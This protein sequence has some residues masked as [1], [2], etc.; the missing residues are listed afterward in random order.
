MWEYLLLP[1]AVIL[2]L[3]MMIRPEWF[4]KAEHFLDVVDGKPTEWYLAKMRLI[5][6]GLFLIGAVTGIALLIL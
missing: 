6:A 2:G 5:G 3:I 1:L 4:W